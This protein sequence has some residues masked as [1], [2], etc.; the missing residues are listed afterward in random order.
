MMKRKKER[1][2]VEN[3]GERRG[4]EEGIRKRKKQG[5]GERREEE[6]EEEE[7]IKGRLTTQ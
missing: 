4:K 5:E 3:E 1:I 6:E 2:G 7:E